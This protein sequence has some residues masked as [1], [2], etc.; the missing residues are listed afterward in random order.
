MKQRNRI[1]NG[2]LLLYKV[3]YCPR[4]EV[5]RGIYPVGNDV[6]YTRQTRL[7]CRSVPS[8]KCDRWTFRRRASPLHACAVVDDDDEDSVICRASF[9]DRT[10]T[11]QHYCDTQWCRGID[12][13]DA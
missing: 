10:S 1:L 8:L 13:I 11:D 3:E 6:L 9:F 2:V 7:P 5:R 12:W 4:G